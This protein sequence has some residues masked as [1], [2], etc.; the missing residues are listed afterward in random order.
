MGRKYRAPDTRTCCSLKTKPRTLSLKAKRQAE[1]LG[2]GVF[3]MP[4]DLYSSFVISLPSHSLQPLGLGAG[5]T[6]QLTQPPTAVLP[7]R[8][9]AGT[10][11]PCCPAVALPTKRGLRHTGKA[12]EEVCSDPETSPQ[13]LSSLAVLQS[14]RA[15]SSLYIIIIIVIITIISIITLINIFT[16]ITIFPT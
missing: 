8:A 13:C 14:H 5:V 7:G 16:I 10:A 2:T 4:H 6:P 1:R 3:L 15:S 12:A 9:R 11:Q